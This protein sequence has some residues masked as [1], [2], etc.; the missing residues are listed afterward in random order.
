MTARDDF[1]LVLH[2]WFAT[3]AHEAA[4]AGLHDGAMGRVR[5]GRQRPTWVARLGA[6]ART[7]RQRALVLIPAAAIVALAAMA[8]LWGAAF[9]GVG[10]SPSPSPTPSSSAVA[11]TPS[12]ASVEPDG[13]AAFMLPFDYT[14]PAGSGLVPAAD[15]GFGHRIAWV[16]GE[17]KPKPS[18][19]YGGQA[20]GSSVDR[21]IIVA[22]SERPWAHSDGG[23]YFLQTA[24]ADLL[25]DLSGTS[26]GQLG[27]ITP[28]D[29]DGRPA[30]ATT[31]AAYPQNDI[32]LTGGLGGLVGDNPDAIGLS[33]P[34]RLVVGNVG[35]QVV[36]VLAWARTQTDLD[37]FLP[38]AAQFVDSIHFRDP[39]E[40]S[41]SV[42]HATSF[43]RPFEYMIPPATGLRGA[44]GTPT[45]N[46]IAW[47][48]GPDV[49]A[50]DVAYGGQDLR[51][52]NTWGIILAASEKPW[53]HAGERYYLRTA[54][55]DLL[56]D[57]RD[58]SNVRYGPTVDAELDG[59][60]AASATKLDTTT[61]DLHVTGPLA[62]ISQE[63][64]DLSRPNRLIVANVGGIDVIV[65]V[66]AQTTED[67]G[68]HDREANAFI[69]TIHFTGQ[70]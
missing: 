60:P 53:S 22:V 58:R 32:H 24:P 44:N 54:P 15:G 7:G 28:V 1:D 61:G 50:Q 10:P 27:P 19:T 45:P 57:L 67:L 62:G 2:D 70:P 52:G 31:I 47:V 23:R 69:D 16:V 68:T 64:L 66:W 25:N 13:M 3:T 37:D 26:G 11:T 17:E 5:G 6:P 49:A 29:L 21:G 63:Y 20:P 33:N 14:I 51:S 55:A 30:M 34:S 18:Q 9:I 8:I 43:I 59:R 42:Q 41:P 35:G 56:A 39:P 36:L 4:P 48:V 40:V 65:V 12:A 46:M 38:V